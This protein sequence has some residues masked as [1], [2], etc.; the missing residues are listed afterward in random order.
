MIQAIILAGGLGT[1]LGP[2]TQ[3]LPKA[4]LPIQGKPFI[5]YQ[6]RWLSRHGIQDVVLCVGHLAQPIEDCVGD[7]SRYNLRIQYSHDKELLGTAGA[8]KNAESLV[9]E[10]FFVLN[11]DSYLP[12]DPGEPIRFFL[13]K[14]W[15]GMLTVYKNNNRYDASNIAA[16]DGVI[17][18]YCRKGSSPDVDSIDYGM[19]FFKKRALELL[20]ANKP[21]D[22]GVLYQKLMERRQLGEFEVKTPFYEIGSQEGLDRFRRYVAEQ[23]LS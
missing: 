6:L 10:N 19:Q 4:L 14:N 23:G 2:L 1:R 20:P 18:K 8:V 13:A 16:R 3:G 12:M 15:L 11:G 22:M 17:Q 5:H 21:M 9:R 7:G